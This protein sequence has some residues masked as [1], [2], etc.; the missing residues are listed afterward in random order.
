[1]LN[2]QF[3]VVAQAN[4]HVVP[5]VF[6][7]DGDVGKPNR[8]SHSRRGGYLLS[9]LEL[10]LKMDMKTKLNFLH[11]VGAV[12][13]FTAI[14]MTQNFGGTSTIVPHVKPIDF[15]KVG[16]HASCQI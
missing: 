12:V 10:F 4:P 5:F 15:I 14:L 16:S 3:F 8:W 9:G 2:C 1:M 11:E 6:N 7:S 13:G